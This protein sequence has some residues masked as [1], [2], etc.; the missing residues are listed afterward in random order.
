M[1][2]GGCSGR[3]DWRGVA[4]ARRF[5]CGR[6]GSGGGSGGTGTH[7]VAYAAVSPTRASSRRRRR[8]GIVHLGRQ[9]CISFPELTVLGHQQIVPI[10]QISQGLALGAATALFKLALELVVVLEY[11][12]CGNVKSMR[13]D[14]FGCAS[15]CK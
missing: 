10:A 4:C 14:L 1:L 12:M 8:L 2:L 13:Y 7:S 9:G 11:C 3:W 6:A 5:G 15:T